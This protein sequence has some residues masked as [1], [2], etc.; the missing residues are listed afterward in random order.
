[1]GLDK[2]NTVEWNIECWLG[3]GTRLYEYCTTHSCGT[4]SAV[5]CKFIIFPRII[6]ICVQF[7]PVF[8][9]IVVNK[10]ARHYKMGEG[11][12][13]GMVVSAFV[14]FFSTTMDDFA[15]M[16][17]FFS[18]ANQMDNVRSAYVKVVLGMVLAFTIVVLISLL[19]LVLGIFLEAKYINLIGFIPLL[20]GCSKGYEVYQEWMN[21]AEEGGGDNKEAGADGKDVGA[22]ERPSPS[23]IN[24]AASNE[25]YKPLSQD[26]LHL[27]EAQ[28]ALPVKSK[29]SINEEDDG[30][31][32]ETENMGA[33]LIPAS[34]G[35][36]TFN[37]SPRNRDSIDD[38]KGP[39]SIISFQTNGASEVEAGEHVSPPEEEQESNMLADGFKMMC[40]RCMDPFVLEVTVFGLI[41]SSDN[42]A[43]YTSIFASLPPV[44]AAIVIGLF[45]LLLLSNIVAAVLLIDVFLAFR[46]DVGIICF[47]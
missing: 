28:D 36:N 31:R 46:Y 17:I 7:L 33:K 3:E 25:K 18:R 2:F 44:G 42:I 29:F 8:S 30:T 40:A 11:V 41:C 38:V 37:V 9:F 24:G 20:V 1:V 39:D 10:V 14:A 27:M 5:G 6:F 13:E 19:G 21:P 16:L 45:Y 26:D 23:S 15:V 12:L 43:I 34:N 35:R 47:R 4:R 22:G 32:L